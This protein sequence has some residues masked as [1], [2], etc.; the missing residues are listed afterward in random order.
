MRPRPVR[1][2]AD[3]TPVY[4]LTFDVDRSDLEA[5]DAQRRDDETRVAWLRRMIHD[6]EDD[7]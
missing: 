7:R 1:H 2:R 3:G 6:E 4:R 5:L